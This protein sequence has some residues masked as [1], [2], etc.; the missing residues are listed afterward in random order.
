MGTSSP[1]GYSEKILRKTFTNETPHAGPN[2]EPADFVAVETA[3]GKRVFATAHH[4][5]L[6]CAGD[7]QVNSAARDFNARAGGF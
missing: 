7:L 2:H 4:L 6:T 3:G 5:L 1:S